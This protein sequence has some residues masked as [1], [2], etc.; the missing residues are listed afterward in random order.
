[1]QYKTQSEKDLYYQKRIR[2]R[3]K[4]I[5]DVTTSAEP[6]PKGKDDAPEGKLLHSEIR[7]LK[8][9]SEEDEIDDK[10]KSIVLKNGFRMNS[11]P[12][13]PLFVPID[14]DKTA[15]EKKEDGQE[16]VLELT[17]EPEVVENNNGGKSD[18]DDEE[19]EDT[20]MPGSVGFVTQAQ[21]DAIR[22]IASLR[23]VHL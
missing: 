2:Q 5:N 23:E 14:T 19:F 17:I 15:V 6:S 7:L 13:T 9:D 3:L 12:S 11:N 4:K 1:M 16:F 20:A 10:K 18:G 8:C 21:L 22:Q